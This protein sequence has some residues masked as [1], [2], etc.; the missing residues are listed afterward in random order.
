MTDP[1]QTYRAYVLRLWRDDEALPW[2]ATL[3]DPDGEERHFASV[4][5]F[6]DYLLAEAAVDEWPTAQPSPA[7]DA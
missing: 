6:G 1:S 4:Q 7:R 5:A 3:V 2:R